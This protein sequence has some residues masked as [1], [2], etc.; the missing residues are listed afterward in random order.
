MYEIHI[1]LDILLQKTYTKK[2]YWTLF[3]LFIGLY[4]YLVLINFCH[5]PHLKTRISYPLLEKIKMTILPVSA[6]Q[7]KGGN[8]W[9]ITEWMSRQIWT[10]FYFFPKHFHISIWEKFWTCCKREEVHKYSYQSS[11]QVLHHYFQISR[12]TVSIF[13]LLGTCTQELGRHRVYLQ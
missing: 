10:A 5:A 11:V 12:T 9:V 8:Q 1:N 2:F 13:F 4:K 7:S 3:T 6:F